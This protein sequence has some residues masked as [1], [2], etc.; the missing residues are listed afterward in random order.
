ML[1]SGMSSLASRVDRLRQDQ[2]SAALV[3]YAMLVG[4]IAV[5]CAVA[6]TTMGTEISTAFSTYASKL[7]VL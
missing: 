4:L 1:V 3:E 2:R 5:V 6:V 7:S